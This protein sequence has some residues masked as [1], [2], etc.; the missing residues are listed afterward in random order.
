MGSIQFNINKGE[1]RVIPNVQLWRLM[2]VSGKS[3]INMQNS[4]QRLPMIFGRAYL[5]VFPLP[6]CPSR[7]LGHLRQF[8]LGQ[9]GLDSLS[10]KLVPQYFD[11]DWN[12]LSRTK[13]P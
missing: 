7:N 13:S 4:R 5:A 9:I 3:G 8:W 2:R 12:Q 1:K 10:M 11:I 6:H